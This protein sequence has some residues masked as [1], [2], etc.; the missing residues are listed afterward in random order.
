[1]MRIRSKHVILTIAACLA[2]GGILLVS[3]LIHGAR[4]AL[5]A[6]TRSWATSNTCVIITRYISES[7]SPRWPTS[8]DDLADITYTD[9]HPY[10]PAERAYYEQNVSIDFEATL[11]DVAVMTQANFDAVQ[12]VGPDNQFQ[13]F[14]FLPVIEAARH[15][16]NE[17]P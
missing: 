17:H 10:W 6:E 5:E 3:I 1:M 15:A 11:K 14:Q 12:P 13:D 4:I 9:Q 16:I 8:W 7:P 2:L